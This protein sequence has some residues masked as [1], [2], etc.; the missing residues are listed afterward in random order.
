MMFQFAPAVEV[1]APLSLGHI[2]R[3]QNIKADVVGH[4]VVLAQDVVTV[5]KR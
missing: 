1:F 2:H 5:E 3:V 4:P